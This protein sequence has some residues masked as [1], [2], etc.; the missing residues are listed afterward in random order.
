MFLTAKPGSVAVLTGAASTPMQQENA[1]SDIDYRQS[2]S[3]YVP[4]KREAFMR[5]HKLNLLDATVEAI[6][7]A[8][9]RVMDADSSDL[10]LF[11]LTA[12]H[13]VYYGKK[14]SKVTVALHSGSDSER[15]LVRFQVT[16]A[17]RD[18]LQFLTKDADGFSV[19]LSCTP[20]A[21]P[22]MGYYSMNIKSESLQ[23]KHKYREM[24]DLHSVHALRAA[25]RDGVTKRA[26]IK[27]PC[28][29][30]SAASTIANLGLPATELH[31]LVNVSA[32]AVSDDL[33]TSDLKCVL[34]GARFVCMAQADAHQLLY[35]KS[36]YFEDN[37]AFTAPDPVLASPAPAAA[38]TSSSAS[39]PLGNVA[40][41]ITTLLDQYLQK[42]T[43]SGV[44]F[45]WSVAHRDQ[46][47]F[48][49]RGLDQHA[50]GQVGEVFVGLAGIRAAY[51]VSPS[52][53][54]DMHLMTAQGTEKLLIQSGSQ[55]VLQAL[56]RLYTG[57]R[58]I[59][60]ILE[61]LTHT[62]GLPHLSS[63]D[64]E[65]DANLLQALLPVGDG[66]N[67]QEPD[68]DRVGR[69]AKLLE[70]R[71]TLVA[72]PGEVVHHSALGYAVLGHCL[73]NLASTLK[74]I[75]EEFGM[76]SSRIDREHIHAD[77][78]GDDTYYLSNCGVST[79][80]D[81]A[82]FLASVEKSTRDPNVH[83]LL[84]NALMPCYL[85][86]D[87]GKAGLHSICNGGMESC[88]IRLRLAKH[89]QTAKSSERVSLNV[90]FKF[91]ERP[92]Q[93]S[94][95]MVW[96]PGLHTGIAFSFKGLIKDLFGKKHCDMGY[97]KKSKDKQFQAKHLIKA[98]VEHA[99]A[100]L[101][102]E[103]GPW[104]DL[105]RQADV[106]YS[107]TPKLPPNY[108]EY[109]TRCSTGVDVPESPWNE[110]LENSALFKGDGTP[111][112]PLFHAYGEVRRQ[113][114]AVPVSVQVSDDAV[115]KNLQ[116]IRITKKQV[117][118]NKSV[119]MLED[120]QTGELS[121]LVY[122]KTIKIQA[123]RAA[124]EALNMAQGGFRRVSPYRRGDLGEAVT[125]HILPNKILGVQHRGCV[126]VSRSAVLDFKTQLSN[127][128][129]NQERN[130]LQSNQESVSQKYYFWK[131]IQ[132]DISGADA[133]GKQK[134]IEASAG[135]VV[136]AGLLGLGV[137]AVAGAALARPRPYYY[138]PPPPPPAPYY[139]PYYPYRRRRP[140]RYYW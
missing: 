134:P 103:R 83:P 74:N 8:Q 110:I 25:L 112:Y 50:I 34:V 139:Y 51:S 21:I 76:G 26:V 94:T 117:D 135:A 105:D 59:P 128:R 11:L 123:G 69:F 75:F 98:L 29:T 129:V 124:A 54:T 18:A 39:S 85:T 31:L 58:R 6:K 67:K 1:E 107:L 57:K 7:K 100:A 113:V 66:S 15:K 38:A 114:S 118:N 36:A 72:G 122:D 131:A 99:A 45:S 30:P 19:S 84:A 12:L 65:V 121:Q 32:G 81:L 64:A 47:V 46:V 3:L 130:R 44:S 101:A 86:V 68:Q 92:G 97:G 63:I 115:L 80:N 82:R 10:R 96:I 91:G 116:F 106:T 27:I 90:F 140:Y 43:G 109:R 108:L 120:S 88:T 60:T 133:A 37:H 95:M 33:Q 2:V 4:Y 137:G 77:Y 62:S 23:T 73:P 55:R 41:T 78:P 70:E 61:L 24:Y 35:T 119:Y 138:Y 13:D 17:N 104:F 28:Y 87:Y 52:T 42:G 111:F 56:R 89:C 53:W 22:S 71:T 48:S 9:M 5:H 125:I 79:T 127:E 102:E 132:S 126:Y 14:R 49:H 16:D 136:G 93:G 20:T 40:Q